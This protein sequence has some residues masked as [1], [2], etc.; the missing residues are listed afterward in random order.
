MAKDLVVRLRYMGMLPH[1]GH[2]AYRFQLE[3]P[4]NSIRTAVLTIDD[5]LFRNHLLMFQEAP[6]LCYQKMLTDFANETVDSP[7]CARAEV[8][9]A[10][11]A[12]YRN[13]H[14]FGKAPRK[15]AFR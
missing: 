1:I 11:V 2:R 6:D 7:I 15:A 12:S 4:D 3:A 13:S 9:E 10:E 5:N 8:T 14:P